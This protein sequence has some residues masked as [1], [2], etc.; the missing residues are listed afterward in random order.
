M[1]KAT[2]KKEVSKDVIEFNSWKHVRRIFDTQGS[3]AAVTE[4]QEI[5]GES[6]KLFLANQI[7]THCL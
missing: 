3:E 4:L 2:A 1:A 5:T 7:F 6:D